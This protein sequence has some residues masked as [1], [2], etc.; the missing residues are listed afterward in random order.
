MAY[1]K[2]RKTEGAWWALVTLFN[3]AGNS[4]ERGGGERGG[5]GRVDGRVGG[6]GEEEKRRRQCQ[7]P[8][9]DKSRRVKEENSRT[10]GQ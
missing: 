9:Y 4:I 10:V 2:E 1:A 6:R 3:A 5:S 8:Q 7:T